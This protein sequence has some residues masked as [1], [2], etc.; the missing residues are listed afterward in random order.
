MSIR[1]GS[2][3]SRS[4]GDYKEVRLPNS[5]AVNSL[6]Y[7]CGRD[8]RKARSVRR[9]YDDDLDA[10]STRS[11]GSIF[12]WSS[13][14]GQVY[15]VETT[16]PYWLVDGD[17]SRTVSS[18][19]SR[20]HKSS[21]KPRAPRTSSQRNPAAPGLWEK[22]HA[23]VDDYDDDEDDDNDYSTTSDE[24]SYHGGPIPGPMPHSQPHPGMMPG[25]PPAGFQTMYG[26]PP[27]PPPQQQPQGAASHHMPPAG[28][29]MPGPPPPVPGATGMAPPPRPPGGQFIPG[30]G[31]IQVFA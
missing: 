17:E 13:G 11:S 6:I 30:R 22:R 12:S 9:Y 1:P 19:S 24:S 23:T 26:Y 28:F 10:R 27:P 18:S 14:S 15:L 5:F 7:F 4:S 20:K 25:G 16:S 3:A 2:S 8:F 31:G 29:H 21:R